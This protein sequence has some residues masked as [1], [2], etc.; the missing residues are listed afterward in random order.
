MI[1]VVVHLLLTTV[2]I[3][4]QFHQRRLTLL[5]VVHPP[6][7]L[8]SSVIDLSGHLGRLAATVG[9]DSR[10][11]L[12]PHEHIVLLL[13]LHYRLL[14]FGGLLETCPLDQITNR[15]GWHP[16]LGLNTIHEVTVRRLRLRR[17]H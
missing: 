5:R 7:V 10:A 14:Q 11:Y 3:T 13:H 17:L 4:E 12:R 2:R 6:L 8:R 9:P 16:L 15:H 1:I